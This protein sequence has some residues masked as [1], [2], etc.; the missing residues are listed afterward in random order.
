MTKSQIKK[1]V[2]VSEITEINQDVVELSDPQ[3]YNYPPRYED[4][5]DAAII[6]GVSAY[7]QYM[8]H[9]NPRQPEKAV[10]L[11]TNILELIA[12]SSGNNVYYRLNILLEQIKFVME[13]VN[14]ECFARNAITSDIN[15]LSGT[16]NRNLHVR[17]LYLLN[18]LIPK[19]TRKSIS[20]GVAR[21]YFS[22]VLP[23]KY[24][25][26]FFNALSWLD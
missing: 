14:S 1:K 9:D 7:V 25:D 2:A 18:D 5:L 21:S 24:M 12:T 26:D 11:L 22:G 17:L 4:E 15:G 6:N 16:P 20:S 8:T 19:E 10:R 23:E 13:N 3:E